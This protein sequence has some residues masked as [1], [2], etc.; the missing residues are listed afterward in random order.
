VIPL[1]VAGASD[2]AVRIAAR[3]GRAWNATGSPSFLGERVQLLREEET[4]A[5]RP[6]TAEVTAT[7]R[8][9]FAETEAEREAK[10]EAVHA[11]PRARYA[12]REVYLAGEDPVAALYIGPLQ[13]LGAYMA[14]LEDVGVQRALISIPRPWDPEQLRRLAGALGLPGANASLG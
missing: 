4:T 10:A 11:A 7:V 2:H 8:L 3:W 1:L 12:Q 9:E 14:S 6:G 13:G 5:S